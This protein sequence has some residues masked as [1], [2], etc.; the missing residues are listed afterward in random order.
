MISVY[1]LLD[2]GMILFLFYSCFSIIVFGQGG[3]ESVT[4]WILVS[5][6]WALFVPDNRHCQALTM[7][8]VNT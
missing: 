3:H 5:K 4:N 8:V 1:L 7:P 2:F 6:R